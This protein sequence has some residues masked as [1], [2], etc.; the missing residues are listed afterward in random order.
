MK[1]LKGNIWSRGGS[2]I[3]PSREGL[4]LKYLL[5]APS[6]SKSIKM[7]PCD[8]TVTSM[9]VNYSKNGMKCTLKFDVQGDGDDI[10]YG[11]SYGKTYI[12]GA[13]MLF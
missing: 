12:Y 1:G 8:V 3:C 13:G 10:C 7:G 5:G 4:L 2:C 9:E 6:F 11:G